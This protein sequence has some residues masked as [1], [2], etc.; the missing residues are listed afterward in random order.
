MELKAKRTIFGDDFTIGNFFANDKF[1]SNCL[2]DKVRIPFV[3]IAG[4]TA[5]PS[6]RYEVI[7][8][9]SNRFKRI[10]PHILNVPHFEGVRI[11]SGNT[12]ED[13]EGCILLGTYSP[14]SDNVSNSKSAVA[15][16]MDILQ[17]AAD[18]KEKIFLT[19]E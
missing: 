6:G 14:G 7:L 11:H 17:R 4:K 12:D 1:L 3:K 2:E 15:L 8:D 9:H 13:T 10:M 5:I 19:I 16:L 18:R